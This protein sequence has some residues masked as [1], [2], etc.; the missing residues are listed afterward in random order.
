MPKGVRTEQRSQLRRQVRRRNQ[1]S[2]QG[3]CGDVGCGCTML[4]VFCHEGPL[5][6]ARVLI[7]HSIPGDTLVID[8]R[9][10]FLASDQMIDVGNTF[11]SRQH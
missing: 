5:N 9:H 6:L 8:F 3:R 2:D 11:P 7:Y 10:R 4:L 1:N